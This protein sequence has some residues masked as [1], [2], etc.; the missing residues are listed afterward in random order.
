MRLPTP[1]H[2]SEAPWGPRRRAQQVLIWTIRL[3]LCPPHARSPL[4]TGREGKRHSPKLGLPVDKVSLLDPGPR[5]ARPTAL[6][7]AGLR[8][9]YPKGL[10]K[11]WSGGGA[12]IQV[13][14][15]HSKQG[16]GTESYY[17]SWGG[18][19]GFPNGIGPFCSPSLQEWS[20]RF[21]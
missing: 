1:V 8:P 13:L 9:T 6:A 10:P 17:E 15:E 14:W 4:N 2:P 11:V 5:P 3:D 21:L 12:P 18:D 7:Q 20:P 16:T 19:T